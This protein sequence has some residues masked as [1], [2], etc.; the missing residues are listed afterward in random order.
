[1]TRAELL[2]AASEHLRGAIILLTA[3]GEDRL[4][5]D[6][7]A[8]ADRVEFRAAPSAVKKRAVAL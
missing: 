6:V 4:A 3:A 2:E 7:E 5:F 1:M 8:L